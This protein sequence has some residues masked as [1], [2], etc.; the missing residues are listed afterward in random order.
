MFRAAGD[1]RIKALW[2]MGTNPAVSMPDAG[3]VRAALKACDFVVVSDV[4]RTDT[5]RYADVLLP[6]AAWGEKDGTVTNSERRMSRQRPFMPPPGEA[7]P[8]WRIVC[9]VAK[10]MGFADAF[11]F[12]TPAAIFREHAALSAFENEGERLFDIGELADLDGEAYEEFRPRQWPASG[13]HASADRLLADGR[14]PTPDGRARFVAVRQEGTALAVD[15]ELSDRAQHRPAARPVAH[16][17]P[18]GPRAAPDGQCARAGDRPSSRRRRRPQAGGRRPCAS[19]HPLRLRAG[20]SPRHRRAATGP[21]V[22][23]DALER[24]FRRQCRSPD[25]SPL[26]SPIRSRA[27]PS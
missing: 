9:D 19:L 4:T 12:E 2:I 23:A 16:H 22:P 24:Q 6:A 17:D 5:T 13:P 14:F 8:D 3:R 15:A 27:S 20:E 7:R 1:G 25:R 18:H 21:G 11:A 26:R 10:R